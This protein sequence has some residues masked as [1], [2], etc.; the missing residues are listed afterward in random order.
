MVLARFLGSGLARLINDIFFFGITGV[1]R[2]FFRVFGVFDRE[3][4]WK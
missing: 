4:N 2:V 3:M 1:E